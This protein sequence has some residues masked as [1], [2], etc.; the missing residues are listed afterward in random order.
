MDTPHG[1]N[2]YLPDDVH[3]ATD[4]LLAELPTKITLQTLE[5]AEYM[6]FAV[7]VAT[8]FGLVVRI[9]PPVRGG[10]TA[11]GRELRGTRRCASYAQHAQD[12][13]TASSPLATGKCQYVL[14]L[15]HARC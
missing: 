2:A 13:V 8:L 11:G 3:T 4:P 12:P 1:F 9:D 15:L 6:T 7:G 14:E 5:D 10:E